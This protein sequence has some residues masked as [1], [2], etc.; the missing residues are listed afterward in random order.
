M[1]D[2]WGNPI[3][4]NKNRSYKNDY[5]NENLHDSWGNEMK[6]NKKY[7]GHTRT[8]GKNTYHSN[9]YNNE[10]SRDS[11][12]NVRESNSYESNRSSGYQSRPSE[13]DYRNKD[14]SHN[15][16]GDEVES[17]S[18]E[19]NQN[20]GYQSRQGQGVRKT[21]DRKPGNFANN[22][23]DG[24]HANEKPAL[25]K[26]TYIPP[27]F[28]D[29][30]DFTV[31]VGSTFGKYDEIEVK[32]SGMD[33]PKNITSFQNAGLREVLLENLVK[34]HHITPTPIQKYALP[35]IMSGRDMIASAQTGSG[36]TVSNKN[37]FYT[38]K[39]S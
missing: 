21:F 23:E 20:R 39:K 15:S 31:E 10:T 9:G 17:N 30:D 24:N 38:S 5:N 36:K 29:T 25:P 3:N 35:I 32:V 8:E 18:Y 6:S 4:L 19:S 33:V 14:A 7:N 11:W 13:N 34:C 16:W 26:P 1:N 22:D 28:E 2:S 12:G 37:I 27:D